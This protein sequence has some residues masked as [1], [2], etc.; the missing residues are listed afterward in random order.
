[1]NGK[2]VNAKSAVTTLIYAALS[3]LLILAF[4]LLQPVFT[5]SSTSF[6]LIVQNQDHVNHTIDVTLL[7]GS[8][9]AVFGEQLYVEELGSDRTH[10]DLSHERYVAK[11]EVDGVEVRRSLWADSVR[12]DIIVGR[13]DGELDVQILPAIT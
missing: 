4:A 7:N 6:P 9:E 12:V 1:M 2:R 10:V 11:V 3:I 13:V 5:P 8:G